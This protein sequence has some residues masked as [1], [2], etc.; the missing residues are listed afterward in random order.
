[1]ALE[2]E[3]EN[4]SGV[5]V[6]Y[7]KVSGINLSFAG[8][9][10]SIMLAGYLSKEARDADKEQVSLRQINIENKIFDNYF[11]LVKMSETNAIQLAYNY[12]ADN[13]LTLK[14]ATLI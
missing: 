9:R 7:W 3:I 4:V 11:S 8:K 14:D 12:I 1:M 10:G 6:S 13:D 5:S 2:K